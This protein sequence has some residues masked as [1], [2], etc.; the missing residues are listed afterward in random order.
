MKT[1]SLILT[2]TLLACSA[3]AASQWRVVKN[4]FIEP[5]P[6]VAEVHASTITETTPGTFVA[7]W[8]G[9][10]K[11]DA[12][13]VAIWVSRYENGAWTTAVPVADGAQPDGTRYSTYNPVLYTATDGRLALFFK[14]GPSPVKWWG[15]MML[16]KDG[17]RTWGDRK[18]LP[19]NIIGPVRNKAVRLADGTL[20]CPSAREYTKKDWRICFETTDENFT[21][22]KNSGDID[23]PGNFRSIQPTILVAPD[24]ALMALSRSMSR[25]ISRTWS[26]DGGKTWTPLSGTGIFIPNS[27]IDAVNLRGGGMLLVYNPSSQQAIKGKSWGVRCPLVVDY[28]DDGEK[29]ERVATLETVPVRN[30]YAYPA[31]IQARDGRVHIT[32]T[33]NRARIKH[34][35]LERAR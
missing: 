23:D 28:S 3:H 29:W 21:D 15:E 30:G 5:A 35:V 32:Y 25:E 16:S 34:A 1:P 27:G 2:A 12:P 8:F 11:E 24:G 6:A 4:D 13:D 10:S 19:E 9:G 17:G 31:I 20:L 18:R 22:W 26:R 7:S 14:T 33:W